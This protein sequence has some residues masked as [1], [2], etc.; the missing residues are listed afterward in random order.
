MS[1][2][3]GF[4]EFDSGFSEKKFNHKFVL[5]ATDNIMK[6]LDKK[7]KKNKKM[8]IFKKEKNQLKYMESENNYHK[9]VDEIINELGG[10]KNED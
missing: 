7:D 9:S 1:C 4:A 10:S 5:G 2:E 6:I 8:E 3:V